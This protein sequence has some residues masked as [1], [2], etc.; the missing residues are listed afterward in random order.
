MSS[1]NPFQKRT[2]K[3]EAR[4]ASNFI[5]RGKRDL[6]E[7]HGPVRQVGRESRPE[8]A[9]RQAVAVTM[10]RKYQTLYRDRRGSLR[11]IGELTHLLYESERRELTAKEAE[12]AISAIQE[13]KAGK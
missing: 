7:W 11:A 10:L 9:S 13:L 2:R 1:T 5:F 4:D 3:Q 12:Y 8:T 6:A